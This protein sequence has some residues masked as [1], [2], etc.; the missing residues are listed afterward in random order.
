MY[1]IDCYFAENE[2]PAT[3]ATSILQ[4]FASESAKIVTGKAR[5]EQLLYT[6]DEPFYSNR[7]K[8]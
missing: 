2:L 6:Y 5:P 8:T 3:N 7:E 1:A 4:R